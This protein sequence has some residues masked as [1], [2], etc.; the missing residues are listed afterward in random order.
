MR[1]TWWAALGNGD[2]A[3]IGGALDVASPA[4]AAGTTRFACY[5]A[6]TGWLANATAS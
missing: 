6:C 4:L 1:Q 2:A 5:T 3:A